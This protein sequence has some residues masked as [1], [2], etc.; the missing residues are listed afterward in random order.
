MQGGGGSKAATAG[1]MRY[2]QEM[3]MHATPEYL[4]RTP[5]QCSP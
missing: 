3:R 2:T 4:C 1:A 5:E